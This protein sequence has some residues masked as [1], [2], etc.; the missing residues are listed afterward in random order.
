MFFREGSRYAPS[1]LT[2]IFNLVFLI[3]LKLQPTACP[4]SLVNLYTEKQN[5]M[6]LGQDFSDI[7]KIHILIHI[8]DIPSFP[9]RNHCTHCPLLHWPRHHSSF[10]LSSVPLSSSEFLPLRFCQ[11][12]PSSRIGKSSTPRISLHCHLSL[13]VPGVCLRLACSLFV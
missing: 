9:F 11:V 6:K 1:S 10:L 3:F 5:D 13:Q 2:P 7:Q 8:Y 4:R 12:R